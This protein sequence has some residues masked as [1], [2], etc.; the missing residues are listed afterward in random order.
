MATENLSVV[1]KGVKDLQMENRPVPQPKAG[2]ISTFLSLIFF[3]RSFY[4][5]FFIQQKFKLPWEWLEFA[6]VMFTT[7]STVV[8][9]ISSLTT[10]W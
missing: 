6:A 4:F 9:V 10:Q 1:L 7:S 3:L 8:L 2:G 5:Y